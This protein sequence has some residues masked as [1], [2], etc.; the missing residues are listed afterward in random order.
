MPLTVIHF[1]GWGFLGGLFGVLALAYQGISIPEGI[2]T[3]IGT[4]GGALASI[5]TQTRMQPN[6]AADGERPI[7]VEVMNEPANAVPVETP[8]QP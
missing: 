4:M 5:L 6:R 3:I 8:E 2:Q 7:E 1:L